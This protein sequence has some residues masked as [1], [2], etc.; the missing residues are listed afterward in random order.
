MGVRYRRA[1]DL[2]ELTG[3]LQ[4]SVMGLSIDEIATEFDVSR[5]TAERMLSALRDRF[6]DLQPILRSGRKFWKLPSDS[7]SRPIQLP[8]ALD[9]LSERIAELEAEIS[10]SRREME[11]LRG[12]TQGVLATTQVGMLVVDDGNRIVFVNDVLAEFLGKPTS[13]FFGQD[14]RTLVHEQLDG[15]IVD[16][17]RFEERLLGSNGHSEDRFAFRTRAREGRG[18]HQI[19]HWSRPITTGRFAGG[20]I[21]R[22]ADLG[23]VRRTVLHTEAIQREV[24]PPS[25]LQSVPESTVP[26]LREHLST[27][28]EAAADV[29]ESPD[30][31]PDAARRLASLVQSNARTVESS[32]EMITHGGL[33]Y[34]AMYPA[35]TL[36]YAASMLHVAAEGYGIEIV[37]EADDGLPAMFGDRALVLSS[38]AISGQLTLESLPR[39]S[40]MTLRGEVLENPGR[41]R[42]SVV[43]DGPSLPA[44]FPDILGSFFETRS[45]GSAVGVA[46]VRNEA[47]EPTGGIMQYFDLPTG[48]FG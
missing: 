37:V 35:D 10:D 13:E 12:I 45:G 44:N 26:M 6:P 9:A 1:V 21:E 33:K 39:G 7:R 34:E 29:L 48:A 16:P 40:R 17:R 30:I 24:T 14:L 43:D 23:E 5:R 42:V 4:T 32:I 2:V 36:R 27:L 38:L 46:Q 28:K 41:V 20:R 19:H 47:G 22:F 8:R 31:P 11:E 18:E 15:L 3:I 25:K